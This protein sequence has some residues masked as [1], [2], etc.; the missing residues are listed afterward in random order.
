MLGP[1]SRPGEIGSRWTPRP[2]LSATV[3]LVR[4]GLSEGSAP[5]AVKNPLCFMIISK[6]NIYFS[7]LN[8]IAML[9]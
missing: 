8:S 1:G 6:P 5:K 7:N 2:A 4:S 9:N 3:I